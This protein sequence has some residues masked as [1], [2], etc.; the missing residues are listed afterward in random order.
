MDVADQMIKYL[1]NAFLDKIFV[2][3]DA[4]SIIEKPGIVGLIDLTEGIFIA[5][6]E[7]FPKEIIAVYF[8]IDIQ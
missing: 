6:P 2:V 3:P 8:I 7:P 1:L 4:H 5:L